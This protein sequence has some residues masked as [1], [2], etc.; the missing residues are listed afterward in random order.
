MLDTQ[1]IEELEAFDGGEAHVLSVYLDL[2]P[3]RQVRRSYRMAFEDLLKEARERLEKRTHSDL[4]REAARVQEWLEDLEPC[5]KGLALFACAPRGLWQAHCL[6]VRVMDHLAFESRPNLPPLLE[7]LDEYERRAAALADKQRARLVTVLLGAIEPTEAP[8]APMSGTH[9]PG[10]SSQ[11]N[12]Q[13]H[14]QAYV[15]WHLKRVAQHLAEVDRSRGFDRLILA[16]PEEAASE[17]RRLLPPALAHRLVAVIPAELSANE[18]EILD[19]TLEIER[20]VEREVEE[21]LLREALETAGAGGRVTCGLAPTLEALWLGD[22]QT[23]LVADAVDIGGSECPN[24]GRLAPEGVATC[25]ACGT[26][27]RPVHDLFHLARDR[28]LELAGR[29]EI[30]HG[31]AAR[32][33]REAGGG[34]VAILHYRPPATQATSAEGAW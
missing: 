21:T 3:A 6:P 5:G 2:D 29:V 1:Q 25:P 19:K 13:R 9:E 30:L 28:T 8:R 22:V 23:L 17:L 18:T 4:I 33:L 15:H 34:L 16:G 12:D 26:A 10:G 7:I 31:D 11:T 32:R 20:G 14:R 27:M 24:C